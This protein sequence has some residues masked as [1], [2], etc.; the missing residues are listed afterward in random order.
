MDKFKEADLTFGKVQTYCLAMEEAGE[1]TQ[2]INKDLRYGTKETGMH[3]V[4]ELIDVGIMCNRLKWQLFHDYGITEK[5]FE[6]MNVKK[7]QK[8]CEQ[9]EERKNQISGKVLSYPATSYEELIEENIK[10]RKELDEAEKPC[11]ILWAKN[12]NM[13]MCV[14]DTVESFEER[15]SKVLTECTESKSV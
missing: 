13:Y 7:Y 8:M 4:E 9:T 3:I 2:A 6:D 11:G 12:G 14:G 10:L 1:L 5:D 15:F